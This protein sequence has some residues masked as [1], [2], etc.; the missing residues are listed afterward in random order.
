MVTEAA[1]A[2]LPSLPAATREWRPGRRCMRQ[3]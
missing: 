1:A 3:L 2:V